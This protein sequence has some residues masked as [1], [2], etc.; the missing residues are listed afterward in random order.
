MSQ[1]GRRRPARSG[2]VHTRLRLAGFQRKL[3]AP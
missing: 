3:R 1:R 2:V